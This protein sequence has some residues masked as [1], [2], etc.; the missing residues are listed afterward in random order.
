M[1]IWA[2]EDAVVK[3]LDKEEHDALRRLLFT[4]E[5]PL[6]ASRSRVLAAGDSC[7]WL[8]LATQQGSAECEEKTNV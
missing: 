4:Q 8:V 2:N 6:G 7:Q 3:C 5:D 1:K